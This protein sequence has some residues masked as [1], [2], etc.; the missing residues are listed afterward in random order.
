MPLKFKSLCILQPDALF[1]LRLHVNLWKQGQMEW[2]YNLR[3]S[4]MNGTTIIIAYH[5]EYHMEALLCIYF[6]TLVLVCSSL[7]GLTW[8]LKLFVAYWEGYK[9][10]SN[11]VF[12]LIHFQKCFM[13]HFSRKFL[14]CIQ[15]S[16][17]HS[18]SWRKK[19]YCSLFSLISYKHCQAY[20]PR[21]ASVHQESVFSWCSCHEDIVTKGADYGQTTKAH[22]LFFS[23]FRELWKPWLSLCF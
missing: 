15:P 12:G 20:P 21:T 8:W 6:H 17:C 13:P 5:Q 2:K 23:C 7:A 22:D 11:T 14:G 1:H 10:W 9:I 18:Y 3:E 19:S 16:K 4:G